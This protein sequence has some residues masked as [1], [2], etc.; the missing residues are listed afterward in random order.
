MRKV[1]S[2]AFFLFSMLNWGLSQQRPQFT[3]YLFQQIAYNP[4]YAGAKGYLQSG[5]SVRSQWLGLEGGPRSALVN[6]H[7]ALRNNRV[8]LGLQAQTDRLGPS[9]YT[10][11]QVIYAYRVQLNDIRFSAGVQ[12]GMENYRVDWTKLDLEEPVDD[13]FPNGGTS[14]WSPVIGVGVM[15]QGSHWYAGLSCPYLLEQELFYESADALFTRR[16]RHVYAMAGAEWPVT[17]EWRFLAATLFSSV[18]T[19]QTASGPASWDLYGSF[20][21]RDLF[22]AGLSW[23]TGIPFW[24]PGMGLGQSAGLFAVVQLENGLRFGLSF[25]APLSRLAQPAFGSLEWTVGYEWNVRA[26]RIATP[27]FFW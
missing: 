1:L 20:F 14:W 23:Q 17:A 11:L 18:W 13:A 8:A 10:Q 24:T 9:K 16:L 3:H 5:L 19:N 7:S 22:L 4:A 2:I 27:R 25:D 6:V 26:S 21:Y 15:A 12:A